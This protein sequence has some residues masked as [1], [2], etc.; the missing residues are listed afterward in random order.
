MGAFRAGLSRFAEDETGATAIEYGLVAGLVALGVI[1]A[2][3]QSGVSLAGL[4]D[5]VVNRA[6]TAMVNAS[7]G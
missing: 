3:T 4:F 1:V 7:A 2:M 5:F 6:G